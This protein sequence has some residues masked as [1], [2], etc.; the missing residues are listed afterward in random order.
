MAQNELLRAVDARR[1]MRRDRAAVEHALH[2]VGKCTGRRVTPLGLDRDRLEH[3]IVEIAAQCAPR[4]RRRRRQYTRRLLSGDLRRRCASAAAGQ[5][6][7]GDQFAEQDT[8]R[9]DIGRGRDQAAEALL[10]GGI[11]RR[12]RGHAGVRA[13]VVVEQL[14][15]AKSKAVDSGCRWQ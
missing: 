4:Q 12:E 13:F 14:R 7:A 6:L 9:V 3:D 10:R 15:D 2:V 5:A 1:R 8:E 11:R